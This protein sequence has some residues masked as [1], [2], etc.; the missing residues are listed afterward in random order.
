MKPPSPIRTDGDTAYIFLKE[1]FEAIIDV[2]DIPLVN[3]KRWRLL[4]T[5]DGHCYA[6]TGQSAHGTFIMLHRFLLQPPHTLK[7]DHEDGDGLN[8]R[9]KNIRTATGTQNNANSVVSRRNLLGVKG[10]SR[11]KNRR[12]RAVIQLNDKNVHLGCF[13]TSEEAADAYKVAARVQWGDYAK[14]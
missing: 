11:T 12:F 7:V 14:K 2:G 6:C 10:V 1:G 8:N 5:R 9:R 13:L 3:D 4:A